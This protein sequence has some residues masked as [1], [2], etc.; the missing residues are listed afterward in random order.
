MKKEITTLLAANDGKLQLNSFCTLGR[1]TKNALGMDVDEL[2]AYFSIISSCDRM[3]HI[4]SRD[5]QG[6]IQEV[7]AAQT[8]V[9]ASAAEKLNSELANGYIRGSGLK[10][11][12]A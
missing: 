1:Y 9:F 4:Q 3:V 11:E 2:V 7:Q 10:I 6:I 5:W 8:E 12:E